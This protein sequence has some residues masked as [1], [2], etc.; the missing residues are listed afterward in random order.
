MARSAKVLGGVATRAGQLKSRIPLIIS[1][2]DDRTLAAVKE[3]ADRMAEDA[4]ERVPDAH[5]L[6]EGLVDAIHVETE[7]DYSEFARGVSQTSQ[8]VAVVAG[9]SEHFYGHMVENGTVHTSPR[10]F[11]VPA[12]EAERENL[13]AIARVY[14]ANL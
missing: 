12:F 7:A 5:P 8:A 14:L 4:K 1:T 10:P 11:L 3:L 6:G 13:Y 9:D 2:L